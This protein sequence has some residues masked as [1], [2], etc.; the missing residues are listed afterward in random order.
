[1]LKFISGLLIITLSL[2][3]CF[4][5]FDEPKTFL[6]KELQNP[7][8][9]KKAVLLQSNG[10]ATVDLSLQVSIFNSDY[11]LSGKE[12]GN[13]FT[14]DRNHGA[15]GIDSSSINLKWVSDDTLQIEYDKKL[16]TFIQEKIVDGVNI[17]YSAK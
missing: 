9:T 13:V 12:L 10:D 2:S 6:I 5:L 17:I 4:Q 7:S 3:S 1:M 11:K 8:K 16:R 14:V 15:T